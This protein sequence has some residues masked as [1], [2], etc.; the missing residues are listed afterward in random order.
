MSTPL[1]EFRNVERRYIDGTDTVYALRDESFTI[2]AGQFVAVMGPSGSGKSTL[3]NLAGGL[4]VATVGHVLVNG[5]D[6]A[7]LTIRE[8]AA[9][10]RSTIG[11][12]FQRL[13]LLPTLTVVENVMLPLELGGEPARRAKAAARAALGEVGIADLG[14][15]YPD[16][17]SGGQQQRVAIARAIVGDR[18]LILADEPTGSLDTVNGE[19]V[20][21]LLAKQVAN[22][23]TVVLVT[24]EPRFA[25][26]SDRV[27]RVRDGVVRE[28][29]DAPFAYRE[30]SFGDDVELVL[31]DPR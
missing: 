7:G 28:E 13:N 2:D 6:L 3:L 31:G 15:R 27:L 25:S 24:H 20:L 8:L 18:A 16:D 10:R 30:S 22:G 29:A 4:D 26:Y 1:L 9:V 17:I 19:A 12:I 5:K 23:R 11:Y 21:E 14:E